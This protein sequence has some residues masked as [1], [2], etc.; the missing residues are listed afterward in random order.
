MN[1]VYSGVRN[2]LRKT[3]F[4]ITR[5]DR[6]QYGKDAFYDMSRYIKGCVNPVIFDVGANVGQSVANFKNKF[7]TAIIHSFEP[8][9]STYDLLQKNVKSFDGVS[10]WNIALGASNS[11]LTFHENSFSDMSSFL[12]P[13]G[14]AWGE[15]VRQSEVSVRTMDSFC[16]E[17][18]VDHINILKCD[19]QG[20]DLEVFRGASSL[21]KNGRIDLLYYE[22]IF[23]DLYQNAP[24]FCEILNF[25]KSNGFELVTFYQSNMLNDLLG[26]VDV[27]FVSRSFYERNRKP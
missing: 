23:S 2:L 8:S 1:F 11:V 5:Y 7:P 3:G 17:N 13:G 15:V 21:M 6:S 14:S 27:L 26:W 16:L 19:T 9:P 22:A 24:G 4:D 20:Y 18:S 10:T 12:S 25:L